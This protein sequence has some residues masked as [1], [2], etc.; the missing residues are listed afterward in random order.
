MTLVPQSGT[1]AELDAGPLD[2][3]P[4]AGSCCCNNQLSVINWDLYR[5]FLSYFTV[6]YDKGPGDHALR[7]RIDEVVTAAAGFPTD[8]EPNYSERAS[9]G[10]RGRGCCAARSRRCTRTIRFRAVT[11]IWKKGAP[12]SFY[13]AA[14]TA[15]ATER[16]APTGPERTF[17]DACP[18]HDSNSSRSFLTS[19]GKGNR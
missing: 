7:A 4:A 10:L 17:A 12:D 1:S 11:G 13:T 5:L 15:S 14:A 2:S 18:R 3:P 9:A 8:G 6:G 19:K 16:C